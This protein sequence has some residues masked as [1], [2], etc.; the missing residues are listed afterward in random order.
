LRRWPRSEALTIKIQYR[1]GAESWWL[2]TARGSHGVF[3]GHAS[4]EDVLH[5]VFSEPDY[6]A[7][8]QGADEGSGWSRLSL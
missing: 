8:E 2:V 3:P 4:L 6:A 5:Q 1:G 7:D